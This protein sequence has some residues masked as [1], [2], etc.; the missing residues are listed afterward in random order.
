M[1]TNKQRGK[2]MFKRTIITLAL[3][4]AM[5][6]SISNIAKASVSTDNQFY[7]KAVI[8]DAGMQA[9]W[10]QDISL[11]IENPGFTKYE[12]TGIG[13]QICASTRGVGFYVITFWHSFGHGK[14]TKV[15][16]N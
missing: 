12:L 16:C 14:I 13:H 15:S 7:I 11:W 6:F 5:L 4:L 10:A 1:N 8:N 3:T 9:M 2:K